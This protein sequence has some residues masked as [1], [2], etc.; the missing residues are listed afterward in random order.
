MKRVFSFKKAFVLS[1]LGSCASLLSS[2]R[3]RAR[4]P[5]QFEM[6]TGFSAKETCSCAFVV[7]QTDDYCKSFGK[8]GTYQV[9]LTI[10]RSAKTVTSKFTVVSRTAR[11]TEE[12]GCVNDLL[13]GK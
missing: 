4:L 1:F 12:L 6:L 11:F 8:L 5:D 10:D 7:E 3:A 2:D 13:D 9:E